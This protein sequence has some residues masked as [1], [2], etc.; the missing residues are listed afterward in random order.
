MNLNLHPYHIY[1]DNHFHLD[2]CSSLNLIHRQLAEPNTVTAY[3]VEF[4]VE[5]GQTMN[6]TGFHIE[7]LHSP[8]LWMPSL[9]LPFR[10]IAMVTLTRYLLN[11]HP[12]E[13]NLQVISVAVIKHFL[14]TY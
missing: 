6:G 2:Q 7:D 3:V 11:T 5:Y 1:V 14:N 9:L 12:F 4:E 10:Q 13:M 8:F